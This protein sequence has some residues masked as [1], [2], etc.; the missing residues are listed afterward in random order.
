M[1]KTLESLK[2]SKIIKKFDIIDFKKGSNF[3]FLKIEAELIDGS[4]L[5]VKNYVSNIDYLYSYHW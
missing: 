2:T 1:L 3:Y 5:F 4:I